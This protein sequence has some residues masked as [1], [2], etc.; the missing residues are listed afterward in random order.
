MAL[1]TPRLG[2]EASLGPDRRPALGRGV[3]IRRLRFSGQFMLR[4]APF[5][6][7]AT[8]VLLMLNFVT[9]FAYHIRSRTRLSRGWVG[10]PGSPVLV[11]GKV[12]E[13]QSGTR[14]IIKPPT[15]PTTLATPV[16]SWR[17]LRLRFGYSP[18]DPRLNRS[19][20]AKVECTVPGGGVGRCRTTLPT[21]N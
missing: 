4:L 10:R 6:S 19:G 12:P 18:G 21:V 11:I 9:R 20:G 7:A 13:V 3:V 5:V 17:R 2:F 14:E 15:T 8:L 1:G 16:R